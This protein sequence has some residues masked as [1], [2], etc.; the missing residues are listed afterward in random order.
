MNLGVSE[1]IASNYYRIPVVLF[2]QCNDQAHGVIGSEVEFAGPEPWVRCSIAE[3]P[4][5]GKF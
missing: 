1:L 2:L 5:A 4:E 3:N